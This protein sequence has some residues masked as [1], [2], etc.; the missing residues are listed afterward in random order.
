M[1]WAKGSAEYLTPKYKNVLAISADVDH[2]VVVW[3]C[4][5]QSISM[6]HPTGS[7][8][9]FLSSGVNNT[10]HIHIRDCTSI[11]GYPIGDPTAI[12]EG[13]QGTIKC[14]KAL[15]FMIILAISPLISLGSTNNIQWA[16]SKYSKQ[17]RLCSY[18]IA[19]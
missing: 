1:H 5:K 12:F 10:I 9:I 16:L 14:V 13:N 17:R 8:I 7:E 2:A 4:K 6:R 15:A 11:V 3:C 18:Q 19:V